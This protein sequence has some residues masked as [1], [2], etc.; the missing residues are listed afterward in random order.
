MKYSKKVLNLLWKD[1]ESVSNENNKAGIVG[2]STLYFLKNKN[3]INFRNLSKHKLC[4]LVNAKDSTV[5][6]QIKR[7]VKKYTGEEIRPVQD[8]SKV[9]VLISRKI[10]ELK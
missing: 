9:G 2:V 1:L 8:N 3:Q 4:R 10:S 7:L 5:S 6:A